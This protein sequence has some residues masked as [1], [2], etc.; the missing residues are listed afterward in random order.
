LP[1]SV[2]KKWLKIRLLE[3]HVPQVPLTKSF[4]AALKCVRKVSDSLTG[5]A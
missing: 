2:L 4:M 5:G 1:Q 3:G